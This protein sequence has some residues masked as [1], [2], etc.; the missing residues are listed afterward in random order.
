MFV[1]RFSFGVYY[2]KIRRG[3]TKS[4]CKYSIVLSV[5]FSVI[6]DASDACNM[7]TFSLGGTTSVSRSWNIKVTQYTCGAEMAGKEIELVAGILN[8]VVFTIS[9]VFS[10][11]TNLVVVILNSTV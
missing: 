8:Y 4:C 1:M 10:N 11:S 3:E 2:V 5:I 7:A 9:I 6:V